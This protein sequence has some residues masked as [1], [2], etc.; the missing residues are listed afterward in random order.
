M[1]LPL[2]WLKDYVDIGNI[3]PEEL[4][5]K[6]LNIGFEVEEIIYYGKD[7]QNVVTG[8]VVDIVHHENS[9]KLWICQVDV[10]NE[11]VQIVTG[12][13]NV[14]KG[15]CVPVA[16]VGASLPS[17][18]VIKPSKL[19]GV[20]SFGMLCSGEELNVDDSVIEGAEVDGIMILP[21]VKTGLDIRD[22][23]RINDCVLDISITANRPDC[24]AVLNISREIAILL[25][26]P[27][28]LPSFTYKT[29]QS[30]AK[31]PK[32]NI[33][34][35]SLCSRYIGR[36]INDVKIARSPD[37]I[38]DRLR[39]CG[40]RPINNIVDI[41]NY[42]L[43][44]IGQPLHAFDITCID[45][46][47]NI[48]KGV[49][50]EKITT[51]DGK[52][53]GIENILAI[54]DDKKPLAIAGIM[55]GEYTSIFDNTT[56]VFLE[57][58]RFERS[59]IRRSSRAIGLRSDSSARFEKGVD[60]QCVE[61]GSN[62]ALSLIDELG[63][64][65]IESGITSDG[66]DAPAQKIIVTSSKQICSIL[67]IKI[68]DK[69]IMR[70]LKS[71]EIAVKKKGAQLECVVPLYREDIDNFTDL[72]ED[73]MRFYGY[74]NLVES[75][76]ENS[77]VISGYVSEKD[78]NIDIIKQLMVSYGANE[79]LNYSFIPEN[80]CDK[81]C[82]SDDNPLRNQI[83]LKN[84]LSKDLA[85]MRTQLVSS[86]LKNI[87]LNEM[88]KSKD[89]RLFEV[90]RIFIPHELPLTELPTEANELAFAFQGK[91]E[92]FYTLKEAAIAVLDKFRLSCGITRSKC[93]YLHPGISADIILDDK[94]IGR[95]GK[96]HP[97]V[98]EKFDT[99]Q[100]VYVCQIALDSFINLPIPA[101]SF[102]PI[103]KFPPVDRDIAVITDESISVGEHVAVIKSAGSKYLE[104]VKLFDVYTGGQV[105]KGK[106][107][108]AFSVRL[109]ADDHTLS[110]NE[111]NHIMQKI[112]KSL[113]HQL[114]AKLR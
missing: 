68:P 28:K 114:G 31:L 15:D 104:S 1:K 63:V 94:V 71:Q 86:L 90:S 87:S 83:P 98:A 13:Q 34:D 67:G 65:V 107:S 38:R 24:Q 75:H 66:T 113:E 74:D 11:V 76:L 19:R 95:F 46:N 72:A 111:I 23:L 4:A 96:I 25:N 10:G 26:K 73:I 22:Y 9:D 16:L 6:L 97:T 47:V 81:L 51:L 56:S 12:A 61:N 92:N 70:I 41:T 49:A 91:A 54:C 103:V 45:K 60:W 43:L 110:E 40:I 2:S 106:K 85:V 78:K 20:E 52:E 79:T 35:K 3:T 99:S 30:D 105:E 18:T 7:I 33:V 102:A 42:V 48:R 62:R 93:E 101:A 55:G 57:A 21:Q 80:D 59:N 77:T 69:D 36:K 89:M 64:G 17:G 88:R 82:L 32:I 37:Y 29:V 44:E 39:M 53:Y 50:G 58:A 8:K 14:K 5:D 108:L 109:R 100:D 84:P 112:I 27:F